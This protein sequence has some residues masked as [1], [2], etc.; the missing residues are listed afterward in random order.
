MYAIYVLLIK[1]KSRERERERESNKGSEARGHDMLPIVPLGLLHQRLHRP[2][3]RSDRCD[4]M[5][6][7]D[8]GGIMQTKP[9]SSSLCII[10]NNL[11]RK[12]RLVT[13]L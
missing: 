6:D 7:F 1:Y 4:V 8:C 5:Y 3:P 11:E 12:T 2:L 10:N 13:L 9:G